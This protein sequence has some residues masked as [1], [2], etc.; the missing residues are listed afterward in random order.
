MQRAE[1]EE[2]F[3]KENLPVNDPLRGL[4]TNPMS[5]TIGIVMSDAAM[6][7]E[8]K[9][10]EIEIKAREETRRYE[11][12]SKER[13]EALRITE[14]EKTQRQQAVEE[15]QRHNEKERQETARRTQEARI[16]NLEARRAEAD[17]EARKAEAHTDA[18][19][20]QARIEE[21][22]SKSA[23]AAAS[24]KWQSSSLLERG[25][26]SPLQNDMNR[27]LS[28]GTTPLKTPAK[29]I[30]RTRELLANGEEQDENNSPQSFNAVLPRTFVPPRYSDGYKRPRR[31]SVV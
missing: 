29:R 25:P 3:T 30:K 22:K 5:E 6:E 13:I 24:R 8:L 26:L 17:P 2:H 4:R 19:C 18:L 20:A 14:N 15:T 23:E 12:D 21:A 11:I 16:V 28:Q 9:K 7:L 31:G 10:Y 27:S 1:V